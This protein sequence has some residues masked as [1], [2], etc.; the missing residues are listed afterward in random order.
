VHSI[1]PLA[2]T[3]I[4]SNDCLRNHAISPDETEV[5]R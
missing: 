4:H 1:A 5:V 3:P 2:P